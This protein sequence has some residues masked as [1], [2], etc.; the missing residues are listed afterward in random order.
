MSAAA[1][2]AILSLRAVFAKQ[3]PIRELEI[4]LL[5]RLLAEPTSQPQSALLAMTDGANISR[6][7]RYS[8]GTHSTPK[9]AEK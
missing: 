2:R 4:A 6:A 8:N 1:K 3:S 9:N 5:R 7:N